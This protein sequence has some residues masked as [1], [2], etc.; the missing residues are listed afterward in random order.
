MNVQIN[1]SKVDNCKIDQGFIFRERKKQKDREDAWAKVEAMAAKNAT[2]NAA[3]A[4]VATQ[5]VIGKTSK[6]SWRLTII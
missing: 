5:K 1:T 6:K 4:S 2:K 3:L